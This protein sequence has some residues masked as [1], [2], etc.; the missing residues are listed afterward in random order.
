M[1]RR[2]GVRCAVPRSRTTMGDRSR[3]GETLDKENV[4]AN[5]ALL[6]E[7]LAYETHGDGVPVVFLHG[8]TFDRRTWRPIIARLGAGVRSI[9][10]DLPGHGASPGP[11][12][13]LEQL[14]G[15]IAL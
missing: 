15:R 10:I 5:R 2:G 3:T 9:A 7:P 1:I 4:M 6:G 13:E 11:A 12:C 8:L 14:A